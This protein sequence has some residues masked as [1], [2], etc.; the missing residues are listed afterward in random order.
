MYPSICY[1]FTFLVST[2]DWL[3]VSYTS[4]KHVDYS[5]TIISIW[6]EDVVVRP[7][8]YY[9]YQQQ[10]NT[11]S[12]SRSRHGT[13]SARTDADDHVPH[14]AISLARGYEQFVGTSCI[15]TTSLEF[16][17]MALYTN[18]F[19]VGASIE[20][21]LNDRSDGADFVLFEDRTTNGNTHYRRFGH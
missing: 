1:L 14:V 4:Q 3:G 10:G 13:L 21:L 19:L 11:S 15:G 17:E 16:V 7:R 2:I 8:C 6:E 12:R 5:K 9:E 20:S 18:C